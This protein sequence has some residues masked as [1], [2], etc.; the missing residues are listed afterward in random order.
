MPLT[1]SSCFYVSSL[2]FLVAVT[3][4]CI[5]ASAYDVIFQIFHPANMAEPPNYKN[6][7]VFGGS[8]VLL[9]CLSLFS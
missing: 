9:V 8:Y 3:G 7:A 1:R 6:L 2:F 5:F 4:I